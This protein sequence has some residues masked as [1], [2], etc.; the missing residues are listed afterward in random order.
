MRTLGLVLAL[1]VLGC[2]AHQEART[3]AADSASS[4]VRPAVKRF[5]AAIRS[6]PK[7]VSV[8]ID[9]VAAGGAAGLAEVAQLTNGGLSI[10]DGDGRLR[11]QLAEAVPSPENGQW[12]LFPD[13]R[14][15]TTWRTKAGAQWQD[16]AP[17][18]ADDLIFT[19]RVAQDPQLTIL[20]D[21]AF[22][23]A[24]RTDALDSD[25]LEILH[26]DHGDVG[27]HGEAS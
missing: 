3:P 10:I 21:R 1:V 5:T 18:T 20:L 24:E 16:G 25:L 12:K 8:T 4:V 2:A 22:E 6:Y 17:F 7:S 9:S 23:L 27:V 26:Y 11:P 14:M 15:E 19:A 13:G